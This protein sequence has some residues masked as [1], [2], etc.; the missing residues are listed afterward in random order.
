[1]SAR[2]I[3]RY[4]VEVPAPVPQCFSRYGEDDRLSE[5]AQGRGDLLCSDYDDREGRDGDD[6]GS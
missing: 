3:C 1:M 4:P 2:N 5:P 6:P